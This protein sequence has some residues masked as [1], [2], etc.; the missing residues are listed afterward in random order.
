MN[1]A[2]W[3]V[4]TVLAVIMIGAGVPK[5]LWSRPR[6]AEKMTWTKNAPEASVRLLGLAEVLGAAGLILPRL[7][8]IAPILTPIA[9][10]CLL[11][12]LFGAIVTSLRQHKS[13]ALAVVAALMA[14]FVAI[15]RLVDFSA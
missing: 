4:Q 3:V 9:A 7:V 2:L 14:A 6:L 12:I 8:G 11:P 13:P 15:G 1:I 10:A 5:L